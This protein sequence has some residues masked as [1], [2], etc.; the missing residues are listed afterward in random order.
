M[1]PEPPSSDDTSAGGTDFYLLGA[2]FSKAINPVMPT[3]VELQ[4]DVMARLGFGPDVLVPFGK[5]LSN[6]CR[7][8]QQ[9]SPG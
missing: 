8:F 6:G 9:T 2:G 5:A 1:T 7:I 3:L 4:D